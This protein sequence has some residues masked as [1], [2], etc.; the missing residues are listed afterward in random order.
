LRP[1]QLEQLAT[2]CTA[3]GSD[4]PLSVAQVGALPCVSHPGAALEAHSIVLWGPL[5][6]PALVPPWPWSTAEIAE[7][8]KVGCVLPESQV[9][10]QYAATDWLRPILAAKEKLILVLPP[11]ERESHPVWQMIKALI[12]DVPISRSNH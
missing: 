5:D 1:R 11:A 6:A 4:N 7:L 10:L 9:L 2:H 3:R 12:P 8:Q